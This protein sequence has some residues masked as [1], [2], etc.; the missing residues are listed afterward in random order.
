MKITPMQLESHR[1][2][3]NAAREQFRLLFTAERAAM[4][5]A[6][7]S[8]RAIAEVEAGRWRAF[9]ACHVRPLIPESYSN[10]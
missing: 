7:V 10:L 6:G 9:L 3:V 5:S 8:E 2:Q 1:E 4:Q